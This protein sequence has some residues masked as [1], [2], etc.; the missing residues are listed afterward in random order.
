MLYVCGMELLI[1]KRKNIKTSIYQR[2][3]I[4]ILL[5]VVALCGCSQKLDNPK[6]KVGDVVYVKP[7]SAKCLIINDD[8]MHDNYEVDFGRKKSSVM[9]E[10]VNEQNIYGLEYSK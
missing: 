5:L 10:F 7:D 8:N 4:Y 6:Y 3:F 1:V 9:R 2:I